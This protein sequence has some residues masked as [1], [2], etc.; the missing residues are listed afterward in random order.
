MRTL[1]QSSCHTLYSRSGI[2]SCHCTYVKGTRVLL[3]L[4]RKCIL[5]GSEHSRLTVMDKAKQG[6]NH[7]GSVVNSG[8]D[9]AQ[10]MAG[11]TMDKA[12]QGSNYV[13]SVVNSGKD[14]A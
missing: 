11:E 4:Q 2:G 8:K 3:V 12:K 14:K 13:G 5:R 6:S 1:E 7:A 9:K 10:E